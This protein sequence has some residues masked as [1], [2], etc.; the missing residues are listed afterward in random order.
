MS[1]R[2][3]RVLQSPLLLMTASSNPTPCQ[4]KDWFN[5]EVKKNLQ[6]IY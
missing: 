5:A 4:K 1:G 6:F 3:L 2:R